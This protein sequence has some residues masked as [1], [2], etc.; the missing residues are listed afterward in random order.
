MN[1]LFVS[2]LLLLSCTLS[3]AQGVVRGRVFDK[4]TGEAM[5]YVNVKVTPTGG[6]RIVGAAMADAEG[7][8]SIGGLA[9][10]NYRLVVSFVGYDELSR[11][12]S[13]AQGNRH[14]SYAA[15]HM[16]AA[17]RRLKGVTVRGQRPTAKLEVDRKT[18]DVSGLITNAGSSASDALENIPSVEVD[19]DGNVSLRGST[20]VEV[21]I[22]GKA[23]GLNSDNRA[24]ILQQLPAESIERIEVIDNPSAKFSA[25]GSAGIINI[26]LK[27]GLKPGYYGA[28]TAGAGTR[29]SANSNASINYNSSQLDAYASVGYRHSRSKGRS[30]SEQQYLSTGQYQWYNDPTRGL[31]NNLFSRGGITWHA[32]HRDDLSLSGMMMQG[33][34]NN[35]SRTRYHYGLIGEAADTHTLLRRTTSKNNMQMYHAELGYRHNFRADKHFIDFTASYDRWMSDGDNL[36]QD[37]TAYATPQPTLYD[38]QRR[39]MNISNHNWELKLD[40][41]N[42]LSDAFKLQAGYQGRF[43]N[44]NT[45]Q[46]S[47][48][49]TLR[50]D[51]RDAVE[52]EAY[53][54]RFIYRMD[55]HAAYATASLTLGHFGL[56]AGLR[57]EYW[58]VN[59]RSY[60]WAQEHNPALREHPFKRDYFELFPSLFG[61]WQVSPTDQLQLNYSRRLRRPWGGQLNSF[62]DTRDATTVSFGNPQL[63]PEFSNA[64]SLNYLKTWTRHSLLVSAYYRYSTD[65]MQRISWQSATDGLMYQTTRNLAKSQ[66]K[67]AEATLK[68][69]LFGRLDLTT[70]AS[71]YYYKLNGFSYNID[72]QTITGSAQHNFTWNARMTAALMLP[73][74]LSVQTTGRY[75]SREVISQGYRKANFAMDLGLRKNFLG[76]LFTLS[77][78]C[79]DLLNSRKW[80]SYTHGPTF[81]RHQVNRRRGRE[82]RFTLTWN[83]GN[84]TA[85]KTDKPTDDGDEGGGYYGGEGE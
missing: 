60:T 9:D 30:Q 71:A 27:K 45:P 37:S 33:G 58:R 5:G 16:T 29:G 35:W 12:F 82:F 8:F 68:N 22:N 80:E 18:F 41:E 46:Q 78:N 32:T 79:R 20:S 75:R 6:T 4:S 73:Y 21:W 47:F 85:K 51:G 76:K 11:S 77:A 43:S 50:W 66:S 53:F 72:G 17:S 59:T 24:E 40:Y 31:G 61:T 3:M 84:M 55:V 63:T 28:V 83:F 34:R 15:L 10:G 62:R 23:S 44:E 1:R 25:E 39:P 7:R 49:D 42:A 36:Y 70:F 64:F 19:N 81:T 38:Y 14:V 2:F 48:I 67:G 69:N 54:N 74:G 13:I 56:M 52:D 57:G 65:V 26:V